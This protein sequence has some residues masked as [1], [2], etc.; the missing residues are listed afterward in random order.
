MGE[1]LAIDIGN[2]SITLGRIDN[3]EVL[4]VAR[5]AT[6]R[7][8]TAREYALRLRRSFEQ[9]RIDL[10]RLQGAILASVVPQATDAVKSAAEQ[11]LGVESLVVGPKMRTGMTVALDDP[12]S[13]AADL[14]AGAVGGLACC[15]PPLIIV[16]MGTASTISV[17]D[18]NRRFLGGAI[19]PG[20]DVSLSALTS[21]TSLLPSV[22]VQAPRRCIGSNTED[23]MKSGVVYG[24]ACQIDGMTAHMEAELGQRAAV[25]VTGGLAER[26]VPFCRKDIQYDPYLVLKGLWALYQMNGPEA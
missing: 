13:L 14:I 8:G 4:N 17:I 16:D 7:D 25:I 21:G 18:G 19:M 1:L 12:E 6:D 26:I 23:C 10:R 2:T 22:C 5:L 15:E 20:V 3:G 9:E 11:L 24:A